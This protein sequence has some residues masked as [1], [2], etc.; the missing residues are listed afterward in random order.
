MI[1]PSLP[2]GIGF[3]ATGTLLSASC[4]A[5]QR[6]IRRWSWET[7]WMTQAVWCWLL[8]P[9]IGSIVTIPNLWR[10]L[11]DGPGGPILLSFL[12]GMAYGVSGTVRCECDKFDL[13]NS[14]RRLAV[15]S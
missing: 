15:R 4:Y 2:L 3:H 14:H 8:W 6:F 11:A 13:W 9:A 10:V 5:P 1:A 7:F 12:L